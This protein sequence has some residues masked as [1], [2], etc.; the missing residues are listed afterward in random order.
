MS[1]NLEFELSDK[2]ENIQ[3]E[4]IDDNNYI[5]IYSCNDFTNIKKDFKKY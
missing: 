2:C 4:K 1:I 3:L 5:I